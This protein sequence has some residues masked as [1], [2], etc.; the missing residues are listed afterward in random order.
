MRLFDQRHAST[1]AASACSAPSA[2]VLR[3]GAAVSGALSFL[4]GMV[5][6]DPRGESPFMIELRP[7]YDVQFSIGNS[8]A[9]GALNFAD[10]SQVAFAPDGS[11]YVLDGVAGV[12]S[13]VSPEG[14]FSGVLGRR[15]GGPGEFSAPVG[16][17][18][19]SDGRV[20]VNDLGRGFHVFSP[21]GQPLNQVSVDLSRGDPGPELWPLGENRVVA[22][23]RPRM[24]MPSDDR[25]LV[26][27]SLLDGTS[28][29]LSDEEPERP[30]DGSGIDTMH[31][32][33][34]VALDRTVVFAPRVRAAVAPDGSV[35]EA[36]GVGYE[37]TVHDGQGRERARFGRHVAPLPVTAARR[38]A[39]I[40]RRISQ[41]TEELSNLGPSDGLNI[42]T[43]RSMM[44]QMAERLRFAEEIPVVTR[45]RVDGDSRVWTSLYGTDVGRPGE[46]DIHTLDGSYVGT[47]PPGTYPDPVAFG[48]DDRVAFVTRSEL[49]VQTLH[50]ARFTLTGKQ[51]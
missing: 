51:P 7:E 47:I 28:T 11:L 50:V 17:T 26:A 13:H 5:G 1:V 34:A 29:G 3:T 12:V 37:V 15:G 10:V 20:I 8:D 32:D 43:I 24:G 16:L 42:E 31:V 4:F 46:T 14:S 30:N 45:V 38:E 36:R 35:V 27:F 49:G 2:R 39:E 19:M 48:P 41:R 18:V 25:P 44:A 23:R 9:V 40:A 21:A 6:C 33:P 22:Q